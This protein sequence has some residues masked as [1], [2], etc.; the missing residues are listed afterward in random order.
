MKHEGPLLEALTR[1]LS[2]TPADFLLP[3]IPINAVATE[4]HLTAVLNDH[5]IAMG[6]PPTNEMLTK[7]RKS[8]ASF[9]TNHTSLIAIAIWLLHEE[10][11][12]KRRDLA[13]P[14]WKLLTEQLTS[15]AE[16][17]KAT[18][19]V[20]DPDRRE[21]LVRVCLAKLELRPK[22][23]T[24]ARAM[25]RLTTL[26]TAERNRVVRQTREAELR[27]KLIREKMAADEAKAAAARYSPE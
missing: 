9:T 13:P 2:E 7:F 26:D 18:D 15:L 20:K 14:M 4:L 1:R 27:A 12:L 23:E 24:V 17:V 5:F 6:S 19:A 10:W 22:G 3:A 8:S 11:F 25:D 21:E 16:V